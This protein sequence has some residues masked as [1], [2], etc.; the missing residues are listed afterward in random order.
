MKIQILGSGCPK[1]KQLEENARRAVAQLGITADFEK[2]SN[3]D[4]IMNMGVM[5]TPAL[6]IDGKVKEMGKVLSP[7]SIMQIIQN[8][9]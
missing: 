8:Q 4:D 6:A 2:V 9:Q 5:M 1:C 7:E 3:I